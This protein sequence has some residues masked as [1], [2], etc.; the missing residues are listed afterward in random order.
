[1]TDPVHLAEV[2]AQCLSEN[3]Q[4]RLNP[5]QWQVC[6]HLLACRTGA[7][8]ETRLRCEH[9]ARETTI[10]HA[11]RDRHCPRCQRHASAAW[12][13]RQCADTL[14]VTYHHLVFT[15]PEI[16]NPWAE[17]HPEVLYDQL[18]KSAWQTLQRFGAD[19]KRLGGQM[20]ATLV[21]HTWGQTL[22]RH[23][24]VH[25]LVP[26]GAW[27]AQGT[28]HPARSTYLF[29]V[30]ALSRAFR[31]HF[32]HA[33]RE[34]Y[35]R[36]ELF[37]LREPAALKSICDA[38]MA[39]DWVVYSKPWLTR[40]ETVV[41]YLA[42]YSHRIAL[43]ENRLLGFEAGEVRLRYKDYRD[44][45]R[46]KVLRLSGEE[47]MRR[48]LLHVLPRGFMRIRH[49]GFLANRCRRTRLAGIRQ[50]IGRALA[51]ESPGAPDTRSGW[52]PRCPHCQRGPLRVISVVR[53]KPARG[54][55]RSQGRPPDRIA[56][57]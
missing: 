3:A 45:E 53:P 55:C 19:P 34:R 52:S 9:C 31:G 35:R 23:L 27:S 15:L 8:G 32:V 39:R 47:L 49:C 21:L 24:H 29:P 2:M 22:V 36:G 18:L 56:A 48:F 44:G 26:G 7:L 17:L 11:C 10:P 12:C 25:A 37:R 5:R 13:E 51:Q 46:T 38:L 28:W 57:P 4:H 54:G 16:L 20:G 50:A 42:R 43:S 6:H 30:R 33:L 1:M 14:P 40:T 41:A